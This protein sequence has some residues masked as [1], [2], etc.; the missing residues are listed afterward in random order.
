MNSPCLVIFNLDFVVV[1]LIFFAHCFDL[2]DLSL[3]KHFKHLRKDLLFTLQLTWS[4]QMF[5]MNVAYASRSD[6]SDLR[7]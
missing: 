6:S 1:S 2:K 5:Q 4:V 7:N 3:N